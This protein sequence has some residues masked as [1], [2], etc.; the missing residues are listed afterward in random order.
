MSGPATL[1]AFSGICRL[2]LARRPDSDAPLQI[3]ERGLALA[4]SQ[5]WS[6]NDDGR[7]REAVAVNVPG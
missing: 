2:K 5:A 3:A 4:R 6:I 1:I 7:G